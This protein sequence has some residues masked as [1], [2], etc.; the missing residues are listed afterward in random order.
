MCLLEHELAGWWKW[1]FGFSWGSFLLTHLVNNIGQ[2][3]T[4]SS[5]LI[6]QT[7]TLLAEKTELIAQ[8]IKDSSQQNDMKLDMILKSLKGIKTASETIG[9]NIEEASE[10]QLQNSKDGEYDFQSYISHP[11]INPLKKC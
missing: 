1:I 9:D 7:N 3:M 6:A 8:N 5:K 4:N 11:I 10:V 2:T